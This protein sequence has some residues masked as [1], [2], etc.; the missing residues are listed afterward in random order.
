[1]VTK[2]FGVGVTVTHKNDP[3]V[4]FMIR[5]GIDYIEISYRGNIV[6]K[7]KKE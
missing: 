4:Y 5:P 1:M 2:D 3:P 7:T 6:K